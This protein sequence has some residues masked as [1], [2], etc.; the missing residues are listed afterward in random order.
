MLMSKF[1]VSCNFTDMHY[2]NRPLYGAVG[3]SQEPFCLQRLL[4][5][6]RLEHGVM[7]AASAHLSPTR[8]RCWLRRRSTASSA[9]YRSAC[10]RSYAPCNVAKPLR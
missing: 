4:S 5:Q 9:L 2:M 10:A 8:K 1:Q 7:S 3:H 6:L